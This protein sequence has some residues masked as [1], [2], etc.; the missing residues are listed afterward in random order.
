M[1]YSVQNLTAVQNTE[2]CF[3]IKTFI[4]QNLAVEKPDIDN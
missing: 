3:Y 4:D 2:V 1:S